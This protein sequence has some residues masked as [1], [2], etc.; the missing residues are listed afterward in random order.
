MPHPK[1]RTKQGKK[2]KTALVMGEFKRGGLRSGSG[3]KV[4]KRKQ[5]V[6]IALSMSGQSKKKPRKR[7]RSSGVPGL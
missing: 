7:R 6:A 2:R 5:A 3:A 1:P 4:T